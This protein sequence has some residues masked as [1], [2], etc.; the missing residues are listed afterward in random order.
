MDALANGAAP[1]AADG[2]LRRAASGVLYIRR[3]LPGAKDADGELAP[4]EPGA[5]SRAP[6]TG[7]H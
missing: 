1:E 6:Q 2:Y 3:G 4:R 7:S 5:S